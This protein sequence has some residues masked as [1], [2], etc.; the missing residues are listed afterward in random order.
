MEEKQLKLEKKLDLLDADLKIAKNK[1]QLLAEEVTNKA[2]RNMELEE[3]VKRLKLQLTKSSAN[4]QDLLMKV[5]E[6]ETAVQEHEE[7]SSSLSRQDEGQETE[8]VWT[9]SEFYRT[10]ADLRATD[11][12]IPSGMRWIDPDGQGVGENPI[13]VYCNMSTG[14]TSIL[15][16]SESS[17][18]VSYCAEPGCYSRSIIYQASMAQIK[19]LADL[20]SECHQSI[21]YDCF[22]APY[23]VGNT[24]YSWWNDRDGNSQYF[25]SGN[26]ADGI[27]TC[28]CGIDGN[29]VDSSVTC[30][31]DSLAKRQLTDSGAIRNK[32]ILPITRLNFGLTKSLTSSGIHKLGRLT[33]SGSSRPRRNIPGQSLKLPGQVGGTAIAKLPTS[34]GDVKKM[35]YT[36]SGFFFIKGPKMMESVYCNFTKFSTD[37]DFQK[38]IGYI[39][40]KSAPTYFYVQRNKKFAEINTPITFDFELVNAGN[41][42]SLSSGKFKALV[43]GTYFFSFAGRA[44]SPTSSSLPPNGQRDFGLQV[45]LYLNGEQTGIGSVQDSTIDSNQWSPVILQS[46]LNLKRGDMVWLQ[47][48]YLLPGAY[49]HGDNFH[50]TQFTGFM[51]EEKIVNSLLTA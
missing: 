33:C 47:I 29:C 5:N 27:Y 41:A 49:L 38:F 45:S 34:C 21:T 50:H 30:N 46:T 20:S 11:L 23:K 8:N 19:A 6:L 25:W 3:Q 44:F 2:T 22:L 24:V 1:H 7:Y 12:S 43:N 16:D 26:N 51:L 37:E 31:C 4:Q 17:I 10:C 13:H 14:S 18:K 32:N 15:H 9:K 42:V 28:Q 40:G 48:S 35:G 36:L 39:D